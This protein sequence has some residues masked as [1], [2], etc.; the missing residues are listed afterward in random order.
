MWYY[1]Q[2]GSWGLVNNLI[3][4]RSSPRPY[5]AD[6]EFLC[7]HMETLLLGWKGKLDG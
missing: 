2:L 5:P 6:R 1:Y 4:T 3:S 7:H